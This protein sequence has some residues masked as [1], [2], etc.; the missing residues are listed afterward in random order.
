MDRLVVLT[1]STRPGRVGATI[2]DW[3]IEVA[4]QHGGFEV[5]P[6]DLAELD[7]PMLDEPIHPMERQYQ[8]E[9]SRRWSSIIGAADALALVMPEYNYAFT[10]PLKNALDY[11][12]HEWAY[13]SVGFVS[14][15]GSSAGMRAVE[16]VKPVLTVLRMVPVNSAVAI[17]FRQRID[18][19]GVLHPDETMTESAVDMLDELLPLTAALRQLRRPAVVDA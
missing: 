18:A 1:V 2:A 16:S 14:Y 15:G 13:L 5:C 17:H 3:F 12:Y 11:L 7:L 10:A 19:D 8:H 6:V 9:H 4:R